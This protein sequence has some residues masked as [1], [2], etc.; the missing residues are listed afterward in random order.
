MGTD[1][2]T[3]LVSAERAASPVAPAAAAIFVQLAQLLARR[4]AREVVDDGMACTKANHDTQR[5][6]RE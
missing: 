1:F 4:A 2:P 6:A 5:R 3:S